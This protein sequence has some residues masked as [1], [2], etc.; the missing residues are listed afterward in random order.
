MDPKLKITITAL[1]GLTLDA[2]KSATAEELRSL[3]ALLYHW[4]ELIVV[5]HKRR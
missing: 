4:R 1:E 3:D 5:E 2:I